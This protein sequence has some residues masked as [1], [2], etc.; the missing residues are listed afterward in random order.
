MRRCCFRVE[1]IEPW[2]TDTRGTATGD[3]SARV[4]DNLGGNSNSG[5]D[6]PLPEVV[7][8]LVGGVHDEVL[9]VVRLPHDQ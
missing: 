9:D 7:V 6:D 2:P 1:S 5:E 8:D 3:C 4:S